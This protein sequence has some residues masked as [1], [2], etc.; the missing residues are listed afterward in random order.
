MKTM[1]TIAFTAICMLLITDAFAQVNNL[2][3]ESV[4]N[5]DSLIL[6]MA[7]QKKALAEQFAKTLVN[8]IITKTGQGTYGY[9]IFADGQ[10]LIEQNTIP[11]LPGK[12][13]FTS[14]EEAKRTADFAIGKLKEGEMPPTI[15]IEELKQLNITA[16]YP[17][18]EHTTGTKQITSK[19]AEK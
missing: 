6:E 4:L 3:P 8:A 1:I 15:T 2:S 12:G 10:L 7:K 5:K 17:K 9:F 13:G 16:G 14:K 19:N 11:G 18:A